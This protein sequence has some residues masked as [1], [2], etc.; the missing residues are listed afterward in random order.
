[1]NPQVLS[2][3]EFRL[4]NSMYDF[5]FSPPGWIVSGWRTGY[6]AARTVD[7]L[8]IR[9]PGLNRLGSNFELLAWPS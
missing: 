5:G 8:L 1:M 9:T 3:G 2:I 4:P 6:L 7:E